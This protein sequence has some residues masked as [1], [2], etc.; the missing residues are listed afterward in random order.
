[1]Q[2]VKP[3]SE[4]SDDELRQQMRRATELSKTKGLPPEQRKAL[5]DVIREAR[6]ELRNK[7]GNAA[8]GTETPPADSQPESRSS[9]RGA[10]PQA[11]QPPQQP[12]RP[13]P[14]SR[15]SRPSSQPRW[16]LHWSARR[17]PS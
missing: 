14:N 2:S 1:M 15:S 17:A 6:A 8:A 9:S 5:R 10:Q 3:A 4:L 16:T 12:S 7:G 13:Q 11:E